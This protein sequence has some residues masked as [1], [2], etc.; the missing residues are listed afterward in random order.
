[1]G[2]AGKN[3][4]SAYAGSHVGEKAKGVE[5]ILIVDDEVEFVRSVIRHLRR[6][7]FDTDY[8]FNGEVACYKMLALEEDDLL[9]DLVIMNVV[10]PGMDGIT[11]LKWIQTI[12]PETSV[13]VISEFMDRERLE[14]KIRPYL[15]HSGRKPMTPKSMMGLINGIS[16]KRIA[17]Q[18]TGRRTQ[19]A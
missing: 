3:T 13:M 7:G 9:Y 2:T 18:Q 11:L 16:E 4:K 14:S 5:R 6:L 12:F 19:V 17:R 15:D 8:A 1:M 10:I